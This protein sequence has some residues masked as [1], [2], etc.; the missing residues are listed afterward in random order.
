MEQVD[1][2]RVLLSFSRVVP[3]LVTVIGGLVL[4]GYWLNVAFL[5]R[6]VPNVKAMSPLTAV[7][8]ILTGLAFECLR[9]RQTSGGKL[10]RTLGYTL[11]VSLIA[12]ALFKL[13][14][15]LGLPFH[16]DRV[17]VSGSSSGT[18][19]VN[20]MAPTT[21][22]NFLFCALALF[23][24]ES[25]DPS[26]FISAQML[27]L[28]AGL[29][30]LVTAIGYSY[31]VLPLYSV[32]RP[33]PMA[34]ETALLFMLFCIGLLAAEP[35]RGV[36]ELITSRTAGG[37][38][39]R[40]LLPVAILFPWALGALL[41]MGETAGLYQR[42]LAVSIFAAVTIVVFTFLIFWTARHLYTADLAR[43]QAQEQLQRASADLQR[44]NTD[45]KQFAYVASHD[46]LEPLR[47]VTS[48]LEL[49]RKRNGTQL[50]EQGREF[51]ALALDGAKRMRDL[52]HDLLAYARLETQARSF[53]ATD[54]EQVLK[55]ALANLKIAI[56]ESR[57]AITHAPL[58]TVRAD[59][60]QLTQVF[61]N[62]IGNAIKF[63]GRDPPR[64]EIAAEQRG[65]EWLFKVCDNGIG[66]D[67]A[68]FDR[69]FVIF[70]RLHTR[71]EYAG[72]GMGLAICKRIIERHGG[73]IW[74]ES[75][76]GKGAVFFFTL[77]MWTEALRA[78]ATV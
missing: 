66:I 73:R 41:L 27:I 53:E 1:S 15:Y 56:E 17:L 77:P 12:V 22:L 24:F 14:N 42:D 3:G 18:Q 38:I 55:A 34:L 61:Q 32:G 67:P 6:L 2:R 52:I 31:R 64:I 49:L 5:F 60:V 68:Q 71:T 16:V 8:F 75:V 45:L 43:G 11:A 58:P 47:M 72:T 28:A 50:D 46:L 33:M 70:Q 25:P 19:G 9:R 69:I 13:V 74:V 7:L 65:C 21:A 29:I 10:C 62:L 48:Y 76:P 54:C 78:S 59:A 30:S 26:K 44:S 40:R 20:E 51:M 35:Q 39:V 37:T 63:R 4:L 23:L 57:A 36:L